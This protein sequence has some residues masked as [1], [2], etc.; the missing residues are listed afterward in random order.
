MLDE[1][2]VRII[3]YLLEQDDF[4]TI[5]EM[6]IK[7]DVS[8]RTIR[9]DLDSLDNW[10][11]E[12]GFK[13]LV[14]LPRKGVFIE[15]NLEE[16]ALIKD[17]IVNNDFYSY[18]LSP[19]ERRELVLLNI[20]KGNGP[21]NLIELA[22]KTYVSKTTI[23]NDL[24]DISNWLKKYHIKLIR[25]KGYGV[26]VEGAEENKRNAISSL[27]KE[28]ASPDMERY[29]NQ[30][31]EKYIDSLKAW[32]PNIDLYFIKS[33]IERAQQ[34]LNIRFSYEG[35]VSL[36][37]HLALAIERVSLGKDILISKKQLHELMS[38]EEFAIAKSISE[39]ISKF[40]NI[41]V[42]LDETGYIT[43]H[44]IGAKLSDVGDQDKY[45]RKNSELLLTIDKMIES[46]ERDLSIV[47]MNHI[48]LK[49][50]LYI[51]LM[52]TIHRLKY[53]K[54]L[55][56]PLLHEIISKY[57]D[58]FDACSKAKGYLEKK[59]GIQVNDHE[60]A[61][62]A[63]HFGAAVEA[64]KPTI[65]KNTNILL[66]CASGIGT[67]RLLRAKLLSYFRSFN[68]IDTVSYQDVDSFTDSNEID[69]IVSTI[70]IKK[71]K[72]P[73]VTVSPLLDKRD[74]DILSSYL[75]FNGN[76]N[77]IKYD[78]AS[79][80]MDVMDVISKHCRIENFDEL[81]TDITSLFNNINRLYSSQSSWSSK[82]ILHKENIQVGVEC[83]TWEDAIF[84]AAKPL[85]ENGFIDEKY[86]DCIFEKIKLYGP[87]MV[88]A[89]GIAMPHAGVGD[90][91]YKTS[92]SIM[93]LKKPV[94][95]NHKKND[96]VHMVIFLAA[97]D[98]YTHIETL[99][100]LLTI[101]SV[102]ENIEKIKASS[103]PNEIYEILKLQEE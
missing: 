98:N 49:K 47:L 79:F 65:S 27:L 18:V 7:F 52:P 29:S 91:V 102:K 8:L 33:E 78:K 61:Y 56:N 16:R 32:L 43:L 95:F 23:A 67:S 14:R 72:V 83:H 11:T 54:P 71:T 19:E 73:V 62:I 99:T 22:E 85:L 15:S 44:L 39:N 97:T 87:Y 37:S 41:K 89:P 31:I 92:L 46:V 57:K 100:H 96:P 25:K 60:V 86:I 28:L 69:L 51:H 50:D 20:L 82:N 26:Y 70:P 9:Y 35:F 75:M 13:Q 103:D 6:A 66:V 5:K 81:Q 94:K 12:N 88:I 58:I 63:M 24:D 101:L 3:Q 45:F 4:I 38:K 21:V 90:G 74:I 80:I 17:K 36:L 64:Q 77:N 53:N 10:L 93:T 42:P 59:F 2:K 76:Y 48:S 1:R 55:Q 84:K 30:S 34:K 68:I 40:F